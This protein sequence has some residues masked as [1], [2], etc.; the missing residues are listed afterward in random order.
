MDKDPDFILFA[1]LSVLS[2]SSRPDFRPKPIL[3]GIC[4]LHGFI[5]ILYCNHRS[6]WT[7]NLSP[8]HF[9]IHTG[10]RD[11]GRPEEEPFFMLFSVNMGFYTF[12]FCIYQNPLKTLDKFLLCKKSNI[13]FFIHRV[14]NFQFL[15]LE[16]KFFNKIRN[17]I[18]YQL[19]VWQR[20]SSVQHSENWTLQL[21]AQ[22]SRCR[23]PQEL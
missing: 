14:S 23:H 2:R 11:Q 19:I 7:E 13:D 3:S 17:N 1:S 22:L 21:P 6:N 10:R 15:H 5:F 8:A 18:F 20:Y 12:L 4:N 16:F 9:H